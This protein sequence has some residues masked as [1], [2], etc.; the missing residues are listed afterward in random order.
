MAEV[1]D[2]IKARTR[3]GINRKSWQ[4]INGAASNEIYILL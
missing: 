3:K 2:N 1:L 4:Y